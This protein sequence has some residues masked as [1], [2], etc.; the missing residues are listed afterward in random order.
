MNQFKKWAHLAVCLLASGS[1]TL[2]YAQQ[3]PPEFKTV[4]PFM[5]SDAA[6]N[7]ANSTIPTLQSSPAMNASNQPTPVKDP[8]EKMNR[9]IVTVQ[10]I[11]VHNSVFAAKLS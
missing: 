3:Q 1:I 4:S 8:L 5:M 11:F 6:P 2:A 7:E 10:G 9:K